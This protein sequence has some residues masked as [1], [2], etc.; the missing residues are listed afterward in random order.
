ML[1]ISWVELWARSYTSNTLNYRR[2]GVFLATSVT[3]IHG[4]IPLDSMAKLSFAYK[5][6]GNLLSGD[7]ILF[8]PF[9]QLKII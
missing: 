2:D 4:T 5:E 8:H 7:T 1:I 6:G 9:R 3:I